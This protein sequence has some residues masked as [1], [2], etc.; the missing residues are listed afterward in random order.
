MVVENEWGASPCATSAA[1]W[2]R[3]KSFRANPAH[4]G[5]CPAHGL[6]N[7]YPL[8]PIALTTHSADQIL[9]DLRFGSLSKIAHKR[10]KE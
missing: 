7:G 2:V 9:T 10:A 4:R 1:V 5:E 3:S 6:K 8:L